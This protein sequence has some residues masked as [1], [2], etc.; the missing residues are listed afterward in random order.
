[1]NDSRKNHLGAASKLILQAIALIK[2]LG[3]EEQEAFDNLP[4]GLKD[5][6]QGENIST[7]ITILDSTVGALEEALSGIDDAQA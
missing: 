3:D 2:D 6:E 7:T 4:Q 5:A 1:M